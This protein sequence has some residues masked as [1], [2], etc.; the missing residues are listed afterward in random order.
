MMIDIKQ[1]L[2]EFQNLLSNAYVHIFVWL[3]LADIGLGL[4]KALTKKKGDSTKGLLGVVKHLLVVMLVL[5]AYP[6]LVL[7]GFEDIA[8]M[9]VLSYIAMYLI[10][11]AENWGQLGLPLPDFV[12]DRLSK[13]TGHGKDDK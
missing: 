11:L 8:T 3:V 12:K 4:A 1:L 7:L 5:I 2:Q 6:Y 10:S 9:F 13:I